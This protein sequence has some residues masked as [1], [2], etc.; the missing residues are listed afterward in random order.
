MDQRYVELRFDRNGPDRL[1][2]E[3]PPDRHVAPPGFYMLFL[4]SEGGV[5]S[6]AKFVHLPVP[7]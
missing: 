4:L 7:T 2:V 5:P 3:A 6:E 1:T